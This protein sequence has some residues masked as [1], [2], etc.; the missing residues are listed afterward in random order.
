M[1]N[2]LINTVLN[3]RLKYNQ[4]ISRMKIYYYKKKGIKIGDNFS[5][6]PKAYLDL[7]RPGFIE[8]GDNVKITR[9][10]M[11]LCYDSSKDIEHF[12]KY[13]N[14]D[15]YGK[16]C[17]GNNVY[18][19]AH[20]IIMPGITIGNNVIVGANSVVTH[21][22]PSDCIIAGTPAKIIRELNSGD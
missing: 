6:S 4:L 10:S 13:S 5:I 12:W 21:D 18:I 3:I 9:W 15:P 1:L 14:D 22:I 8:I 11:I 2:M 7:H 19:G 17:I 20:S 16:V